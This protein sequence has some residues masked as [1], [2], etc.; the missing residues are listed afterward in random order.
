LA[1][2]SIIE[3]APYLFI[4][5]FSLSMLIV[6]IVKEMPASKSQSIL[7]SMWM[8]PGIIMAGLLMSSG[9]IITMSDEG[10][11]IIEVYNGTTGLLMTNTTTYPATPDTIIIENTTWWEFHLM[12]FLILIVYVVVQMLTLF[13]K[14]N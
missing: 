1:D 11:Q 12:V 10:S 9:P 7:R 13:T 6:S 2:I 4:E 5:L 3:L 14:I 8:L